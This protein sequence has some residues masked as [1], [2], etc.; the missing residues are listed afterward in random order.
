MVL[1]EGMAWEAVPDPLGIGRGWSAVSQGEYEAG[2]F[3]E[4]CGLFFPSA[5]A[6]RQAIA[7]GLADARR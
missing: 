6:C 5:S 2:P 7:E 4:W 3:E 1:D